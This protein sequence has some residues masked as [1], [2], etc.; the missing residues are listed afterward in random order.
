[1]LRNIKNL[2]GYKI[3]EKDGNIG[4]VYDF[5]LVLKQGIETGSHLKHK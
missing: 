1:M 2:F 3:H 4:E 5:F